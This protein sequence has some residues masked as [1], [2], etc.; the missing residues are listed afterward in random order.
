[1]EFFL[2]LSLVSSSA[3]LL[4]LALCRRAVYVTSNKDF[5]DNKG[6]LRG[7]AGRRGNSQVRKDCFDL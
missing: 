5:V 2:L 3:R 6:A 4:L 1:M 7:F